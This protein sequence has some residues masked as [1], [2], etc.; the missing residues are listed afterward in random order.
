LKLN[1]EVEKSKKDP[2]GYGWKTWSDLR[3]L[4]V[5][6]WRKKP[7]NR[8]GWAYVVKEAKVLRGP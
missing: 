8:E 1:Q 3:E 7:N 2:N 6:R 4:E 5:K